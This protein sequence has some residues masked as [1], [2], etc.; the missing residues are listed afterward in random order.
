MA[1]TTPST[2][3]P[4][5]LWLALAAVFTALYALNVG[6]RMLHIKQDITIWRLNDVG[7]FV[8]VLIA[9]AFFVT[10]FLAVEKASQ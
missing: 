1:K 9:M 10:G 6:L 4:G 5:R 3:R 7:E 2:P 8:L